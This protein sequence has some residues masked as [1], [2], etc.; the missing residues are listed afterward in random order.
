MSLEPIIRPF[1]D[2]D[3][4]P[5]KFVQ[6]GQVGTPPVRVSVGLKGGTKTFSF[7]GSSVNTTRIGHTHTE[8][9]PVSDALQSKLSSTT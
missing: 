3:V 7:S 6:P 8:K 9:A 4:T 1:A 2:E 5:T